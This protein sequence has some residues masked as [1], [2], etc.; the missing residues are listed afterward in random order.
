MSPA[1]CQVINVK[2]I[3]KEEPQEEIRAN[4]PAKFES[5]DKRKTRPDAVEDKSLKTKEK[6]KSKEVKAAETGKRLVST[7]SEEASG[8]MKVKLL[9]VALN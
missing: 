6:P 8:S 9:T 2:T 4:A 5:A 1:S 3:I 7:S